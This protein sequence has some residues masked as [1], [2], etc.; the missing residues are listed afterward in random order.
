MILIGTH[1]NAA[2]CSPDDIG[3]DVT[4]RFDAGE[5]TVL[6]YMANDRMDMLAG[7]Q[8]LER[9]KGYAMTQEFIDFLKESAYV[10]KGLNEIG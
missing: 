9:K 10:L 4:I 3:A 8:R 6:R 2:G 7:I 5:M 1:A